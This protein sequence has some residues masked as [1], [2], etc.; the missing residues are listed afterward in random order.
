MANSTDSNG[1]TFRLPDGDRTAITW[2]YV[3]E[4]IT[5]FMTSLK[6]TIELENVSLQQIED[7]IDEW[8]SEQE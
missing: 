5:E 8:I 6:N 7:T 1:I 2:P 4:Q 3:L